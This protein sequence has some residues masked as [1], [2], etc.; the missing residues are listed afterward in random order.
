MERGKKRNIPCQVHIPSSPLLA[1]L[2]WGNPRF[3]ILPC[4]QSNDYKNQPDLLQQAW[5]HMNQYQDHSNRP[6]THISIREKSTKGG[7]FGGHPKKKWMPSWIFKW[8]TGVD[9]INKLWSQIS[10]L[11]HN[12]YIHSKCNP[13]PCRSLSEACNKYMVTFWQLHVKHWVMI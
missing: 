7:Q 2:A 12:V 3:S 10:C 6:T 4:R 8:P 11:Y 13:T 1:G 5:K 9:L